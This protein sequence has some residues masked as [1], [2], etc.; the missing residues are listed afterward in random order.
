MIDFKS[1]DASWSTIIK[2]EFEKPYFPLLQSFLN[3]EFNLHTVYPNSSQIFAAFNHTPLNQLK[4]VIIG[5]DPYH[6]PGQANGLCFSVHPF[7]KIPPSL[8]NIFKELKSDLDIEVPFHGDLTP[9]AHS[10]VLLLNATLTVRANTPGSHQ[11]KGWELFTDQIIKAI[12]EEKE[13]IVFLLW[14]NYAIEKSNLI[15]ATKHKI[16]TSP[17]PSPL[18]RGGFFGNQ[19]FSKTNAYLKENNKSEIDWRLG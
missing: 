13:N 1:I 2:T 7:V 10:G 6:G 12:S 9:W 11:K 18:A 17:H 8:K 5:Q 3:T 16:L 19:H 14:G 15:D 4:A